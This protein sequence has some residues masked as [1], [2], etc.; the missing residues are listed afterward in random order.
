VTDRWFY[1]NQG[2]GG[3]GNDWVEAGTWLAASIYP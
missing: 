3:G 1:V 2:W